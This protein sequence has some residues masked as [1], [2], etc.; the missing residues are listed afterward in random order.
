MARRSY[1]LHQCRILSG[2]GARGSPWLMSTSTVW[3]APTRTVPHPAQLSIGQGR[4]PEDSLLDP[5]SSMWAAAPA[6]MP[7]SGTAGDIDRSCSTHPR[8]CSQELRL[9]AWLA[10][11]VG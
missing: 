9:A 5:A 1:D 11:A 3:R 8:R 7:S 6:T 4:P 10:C 2:D